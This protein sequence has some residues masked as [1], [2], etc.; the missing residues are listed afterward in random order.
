[1]KDIKEILTETGSRYGSWDTNSAI[2]QDIKKAMVGGIAWNDLPP[3][4]KES[5]ELIAT[6]ISRILNGDPYYAD[7]WDDIGG[8]VKLVTDEL[9]HESKANP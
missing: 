4:M 1:M 8:Y 9:L 6:K 7:S 2:S 3:Y 5:L